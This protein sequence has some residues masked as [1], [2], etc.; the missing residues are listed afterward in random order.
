ME[1]DVVIA[2]GNNTTAYS[3]GPMF[4]LGTESCRKN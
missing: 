3:E 2:V 4:V 1:S